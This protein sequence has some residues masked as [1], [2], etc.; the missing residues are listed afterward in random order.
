M[1]FLEYSINNLGDPFVP[2]LYKVDSRS[3]EVE[4]L[5][6]F[7][8]LF[9]ASNW[10]G[11][12]TAGGTEGNLYAMAL[13]REIYPEAKL[14]ASKAAHYSIAKAAHL[15]KMHL[16]P[17]EIDQCHEMDYQDLFDKLDPSVPAI[18]NCTM[19][20]LLQELSIKLIEY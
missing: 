16:V 1:P 10:W 9:E 19:A 7:A 8:E 20:Q 5:K 13:A 18:I 12:V 2:S 17:I 11:H 4:V 15:Y 6:F 3:F 14:Y